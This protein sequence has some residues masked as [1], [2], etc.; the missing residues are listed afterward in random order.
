ME[1]LK[2]IC[3]FTTVL[4]LGSMTAAASQL[5]MSAS[6]VSQNIRA[7]EKAYKIQL[8]NRTTRS[9]SPTEE[10]RKLREYGE[11]LLDIEKQASLDM[12]KMQAAPEGEVRLT[13]PSG[14]AEG[15]RI[16]NMIRE[17]KEHYSGIRLVLL[18]DDGFADMTE[19]NI[20][21]ALRFVEQPEGDNLIAR[22]LVT[23]DTSIYAS[24][25]YLDKYPVFSVNDLPRAQWINHND[26][27]LINT[28]A[29]L[30]LPAALPDN[31]I[32]CPGRASVARELACAGM[33]LA[34]L[35]SEDA[36]QSVRSG[37][38]RALPGFPWQ[39]ATSMR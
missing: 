35:F 11:K 34:I 7:L 19:R 9:L 30:E 33:G 8:L 27:G 4:R 28:L 10:G 14:K 1:H 21:I 17:L 23:W 16:Q 24:P 25:D 18:E 26:R 38:L 6:A 22:F 39:S 31:R 5:G 3:I 29:A 20:D 2:L 36:E 15:I 37:K 32:D 13:L 12:R